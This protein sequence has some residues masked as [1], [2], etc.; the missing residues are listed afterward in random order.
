MIPVRYEHVQRWFD[1]TK[2]AFALSC[3]NSKKAAIAYGML[4][5]TAG[6]VLIGSII[7]YLPGELRATV[8]D[9]DND[10]RQEIWVNTGFT[11][12]VIEQDEKGIFNDYQDPWEFYKQAEQA[13]ATSELELEI[14]N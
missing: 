10:G 8:M 14:K 2:R 1:T 9:L 11:A 7:R 5:F 6:V 12:H 4:G 13:R 3:T